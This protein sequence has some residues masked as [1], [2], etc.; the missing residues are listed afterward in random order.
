MSHEVCVSRL[1]N[2]RIISRLRD[3]FYSEGIIVCIL[4]LL[5]DGSHNSITNNESCIRE[6][7][8]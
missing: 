4:V 8:K 2:F 6:S 3:T 7:L 1:M 5:D